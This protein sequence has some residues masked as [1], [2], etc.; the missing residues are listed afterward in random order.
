M[1]RREEKRRE[2]NRRDRIKKTEKREGRRKRKSE[3]EAEEE[4]GE[5]EE[6]EEEQS[7]LHAEAQI[8]RLQEPEEDVKATGCLRSAGGSGKPARG[9][10]VPSVCGGSGSE[11]AS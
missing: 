8:V 3:R 6:E 9:L 1:K 11:L 2:K 5:G 7:G 4:E 10:S